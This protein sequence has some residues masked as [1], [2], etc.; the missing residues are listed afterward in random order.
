MIG[1]SDKT[2]W[3]MM[4]AVKNGYR[5]PVSGLL[6]SD[7]SDFLGFGS[8]VSVNETTMLQSFMNTSIEML[9]SYTGYE[10]SEADYTF[11]YDRLHNYGCYSDWISL[12]RQPVKSI[13]DVII[14]GVSTT[15]FESDIASNPA[16]I[17][18]T[19]LSISISYPGFS[20]IEVEAT[21]GPIDSVDPRFILA[22]LMLASYLYQN[23][24]CSSKGALSQSG[25]KDIIR[26]L[27]VAVGG[28]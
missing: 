21:C 13:N 3:V 12:P 20:S 28:L 27:R 19:S 18:V 1:Y 24:G 15:D 9:V 17:Y 8:F 5:A 11:K 25:A 22:A 16:R 2:N 26:G 6:T 7:L 4:T 10:P 14:S 23:R